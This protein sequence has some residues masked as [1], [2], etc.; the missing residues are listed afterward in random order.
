MPVVLVVLGVVY[1]R[2][3]AQRREARKAPRRVGVT[4]FDSGACGPLLTHAAG[5]LLLLVRSQTA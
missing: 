3:D 1:L 5:S 2:I 4:C